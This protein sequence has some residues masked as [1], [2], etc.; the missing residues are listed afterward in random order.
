MQNSNTN[1]FRPVYVARF[2]AVS[3]IC[4]FVNF[5]NLSICKHS[6]SN[7]NNLKRRVHRL[8]NWYNASIK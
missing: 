2:L 3:R 4:L 7:Q 8:K 5:A 6:T 1:G